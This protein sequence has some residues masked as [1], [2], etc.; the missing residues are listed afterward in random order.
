MSS[1]LRML[2]RTGVK[3]QSWKLRTSHPVSRHSV[4]Q[5]LGNGAEAG[6]DEKE[7][8]L[9]WLHDGHVA[10]REVMKGVELVVSRTS[11]LIL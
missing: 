3:L 2:A 9:S 8:I 7:M 4:L 6:V 1:A 11:L 10:Q 5:R